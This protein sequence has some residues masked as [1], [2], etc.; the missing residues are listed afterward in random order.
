MAQTQWMFI[1]CSHD[2][3]GQVNWTAEP[4]SSTQP[5]CALCSTLWVMPTPASLGG[6]RRQESLWRLLWPQKGA[7]I[8]ARPEGGAPQGQSNSL[9]R[10]QPCVTPTFQKAGECAVSFRRKRENSKLCFGP[11][12]INLFLTSVWA[13]RRQGEEL[14]HFYNLSW[15]LIVCLNKYSLYSRSNSPFR[16]PTSQ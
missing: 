12:C 15:C 10:I 13:S 4:F 2:S 11:L 1:S 7:P 8:M 16:T 6:K 14:F 3:P 5:G 9:A